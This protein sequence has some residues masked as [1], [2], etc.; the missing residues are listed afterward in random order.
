M[1]YNYEEYGAYTSDSV[2]TASLQL[3]AGFRLVTF[4]DKLDNFD[5]TFAFTGQDNPEAL[6]IGWAP[7]FPYTEPPGIRTSASAAQEPVLFF[8]FR[9]FRTATPFPRVGTF[10]RAITAETFTPVGNVIMIDSP[11]E[12]RSIGSISFNMIAVSARS[13]VNSGPASFLDVIFDRFNTSTN[14][15]DIWERTVSD[16]TLK[17]AGPP[18]PVIRGRTGS[19]IYGL[20]L[21]R[22]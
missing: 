20:D 3:S 5:V 16:R 1:Q 8:A 2:V 15:N 4:T 6:Q 17:P 18:R 12:H 19:I 10:I 22:K 21:I 9:A 7:H 14:T 13:Q 11:K